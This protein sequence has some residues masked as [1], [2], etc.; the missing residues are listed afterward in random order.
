V[1]QTERGN[2]KSNSLRNSILKRLWTC[3]KIDYVMMMMMMMRTMMMMMG[4]ARK[5]ERE[6]GTFNRY[7]K[8]LRGV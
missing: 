1:L 7:G 4:K 5:K 6:D 8:Y 2:A 3:R